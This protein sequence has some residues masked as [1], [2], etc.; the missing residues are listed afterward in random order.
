MN[1]L[2]LDVRYGIRMLAKRPAFSLLIILSLALS[3]R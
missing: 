2:L 3:R 1:R